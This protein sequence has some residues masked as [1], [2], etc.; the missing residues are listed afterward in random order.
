LNIL[1]QTYENLQNHKQ[2][3]ALKYKTY[4][5]KSHKQIEYIIGEKVLVYYPIA[6]NETL[7]YK[8]GIRWRGPFEIMARIDPVTYRIKQEGRNAIKTFPVH[9]QRMKRCVQF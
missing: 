3:V 4:Y 6:E 7:K 2:S 5:D 1:R 8:L 9:V